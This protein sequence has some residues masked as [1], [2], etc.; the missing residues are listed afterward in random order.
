M[1]AQQQRD[2]QPR[3]VMACAVHLFLAS[4]ARGF[5]ST[6]SAPPAA[7]F[8]SFV[9]WCGYSRVAPW[10]LIWLLGTL[11]FGWRARVSRRIPRKAVPPLAAFLILIRMI[12]LS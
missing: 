12:H 8:L 6:G 1:T 9:V 7:V 2:S 5:M 4:G 10:Q 11:E 3:A